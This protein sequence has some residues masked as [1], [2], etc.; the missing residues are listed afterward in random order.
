M[1]SV[2][3]MATHDAD[4]LMSG[5]NYLENKSREQLRQINCDFTSVIDNLNKLNEI[6]E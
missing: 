5:G 2:E 6:K 4:K 3:T 1:I